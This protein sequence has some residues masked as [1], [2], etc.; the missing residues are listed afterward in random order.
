MATR[1]EP[2][3]CFP[4]KLLAR[5]LR[6]FFHLLYHPFAWTYDLIA[7]T[8]SFGR[9]KDWVRSVAPFLEG[10]RILELGHGPGHLQRFLLDL[11]LLPFGLD[12]SPQMGRLAHAN[13]LKNGYTKASLTRGL[14]QALPYANESFDTVVSTFPTEY[15]FDPR[16]LHEIRRTLKNRGRIVI[17]PMAWITGKSPLDRFLSWLFKVTG[18]A[19]SEAIEVLEQRLSQPFQTA[20]FQVEIQRVEIKASTLLFLLARK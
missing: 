5:L 9:W 18:Q 4:V 7:W 2:L 3:F 19:P 10:V 11:G 12:E 14:A 6:L 8:V 17:L 20:G 1:A 16:T 15:I 13:L